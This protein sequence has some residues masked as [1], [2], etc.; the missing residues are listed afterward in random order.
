MF[1]NNDER[2]CGAKELIQNMLNLDPNSKGNYSEVKRRRNPSQSSLKAIIIN[3][4][5][6]KKIILTF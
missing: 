6:R 3:E 4:F 5:Q 2:H 1:T